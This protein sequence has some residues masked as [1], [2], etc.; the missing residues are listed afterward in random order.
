MNGT[1]SNVLSSKGF[2]FITGENG[3]EYF[4]HMSETLD[5]HT[6]VQEFKTSGGGKIKVTF[7]PTK[8]PKGPRA[9]NIEIVEVMS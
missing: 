1:V 3:Q 8:S 4:F 9:G 6:L 5:W 2:G 7:E